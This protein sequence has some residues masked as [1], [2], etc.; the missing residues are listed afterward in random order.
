MKLAYKRV[1]VNFDLVKGGQVKNPLEN[2]INDTLPAGDVKGVYFISYRNTNAP[3]AP[4]PSGGEGNNPQFSKQ[5]F[6][7]GF[8][9]YS[10]TDIFL[11]DSQSRPLTEPTDIQDFYHKQGGYLKGYKELD[12][13]SNNEQINIRWQT[14]AGQPICG[15]FIFVI[16]QSNCEC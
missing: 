8:S 3:I 2:E 14:H 11:N 15:E 1:K 7:T 5:S 13:K 10:H 4:P 12:F 6:A 9:P 16:E